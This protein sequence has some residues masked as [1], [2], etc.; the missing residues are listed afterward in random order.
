M[1]LIEGKF[2]NVERGSNGN[3]IFKY[4]SKKDCFGSDFIRIERI[5]VYMNACD[6]I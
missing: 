5:E 4:F 1:H 6:N 3:R 2:T